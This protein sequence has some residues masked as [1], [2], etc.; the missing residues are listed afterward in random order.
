MVAE[1]LTFQNTLQSTPPF[2]IRTD[3]ALAVVSVLSILKMKTAA[4]L[5]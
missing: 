4:A 2:V 3:D 1:L 5:P